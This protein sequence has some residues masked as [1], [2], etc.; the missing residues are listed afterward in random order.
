[1]T[2][3]ERD[4]QAG[5]DGS[6]PINRD[7]ADEPFELGPHGVPQAPDP[8]AGKIVD[9]PGH[10]PESARAMRPKTGEPFGP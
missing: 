4:Q 7:V 10:D 5:E 6:R 2:D 9:D 3:T 1:M 8:Q